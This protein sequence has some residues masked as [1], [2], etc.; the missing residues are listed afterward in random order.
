MK[1]VLD[2]IY[3]FGMKMGMN[4][5]SSNPRGNAGQQCV[6]MCAEHLQLGASVPNTFSCRD[7]ANP[8]I[9]ATPLLQ[10]LQEP[11]LAATS[12]DLVDS[13]LWHSRAGSFLHAPGCG[14]Q[15]FFQETVNVTHAIG[16]G[17]CVQVVSEK[18]PLL[19]V[20]TAALSNDAC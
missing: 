17:D 5:C 20:T 10:D 18:E 12:R 19:R 3:T 16:R 2:E 1:V 11:L 15:T 6:M 9:P 13:P 14:P 4:L 7:E 8:R